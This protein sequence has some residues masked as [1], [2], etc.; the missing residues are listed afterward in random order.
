[1]RTI[2]NCREDFPSLKR[3]YDGY[4]LA[5]LD[6]PG[7]TQPPRPVI[8]AVVEYM[9]NYTS[10]IHGNFCVS[11]ESDAILQ[12]AREYLAEFLGAPSWECISVGP[13]MT[14]LNLALGKAFMN[15][16]K[17]GDEVI[18]SE[19]DHEANRGP[20]LNLQKCGVIVH[21]IP[22]KQDGT[23]DMVGFDV[24]L[25]EKTK[26]VA[27]GFSSNAI[28]TVNQIAY[29]REQSKKV[30]ALLLVDAVHYAPHF[31][32]DV[33]AIDC[34]F[35]LCSAYKFYGPHIG[36]LYTRPG[37]LQTLPVEKIHSQDD[38][39]PYRI[40]S[41][42]QNHEGLNGVIAAI[43]YIASFG[44]GNTL[45][46][47]IVSAMK[48]FEEYEYGLAKHLFDSLAAIDGVKM[49]GVPF[50]KPD[51]APTIAFTVNGVRSDVVAAKL[52]EKGLLVWDGDFAAE[53][54]IEVF[55]TVGIGGVVRVGI[56]IYNTTEE[57]DRL[58]AEVKK[59]I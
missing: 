54:A 21:Q 6:G 24:R 23:L 57:I 51:R 10:N 47:K 33:K 15:L 12:K 26:L 13:N 55:D 52:G 38:A 39:A 49:Y 3:T 59:M 11:K 8:D 43:D 58:V 32:L 7:G 37:L 22:L 31:A 14:T 20:W 5:F 27:V 46:E 56:S 4:P 29:I 42:T 25:S 34:D 48:K 19:L 40:E 28:G 17:P 1:M 2:S 9:E 35:L 44:E 30:G 50:D 45:R 53:R 16:L 18:I 41:G 36:V